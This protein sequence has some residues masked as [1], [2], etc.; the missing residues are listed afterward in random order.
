[1]AIGSAANLGWAFNLFK[2]WYGD[3]LDRMVLVYAADK[4]ACGIGRIS[5]RETIPWVGPRDGAHEV[6]D[7]ITLLIE[8]GYLRKHE[9]PTHSMVD[10]IWVSLPISTDAEI[11]HAKKMISET[12]IPTFWEEFNR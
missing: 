11:S 9:I 7:S 3:S 8:R 2:D 4:C 5:L 1:M 12:E 10:G 6:E